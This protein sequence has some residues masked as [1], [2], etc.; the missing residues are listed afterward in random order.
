[1]QIG[2]GY[3]ST[4]KEIDVGTARLAAADNGG[5]VILIQLLNQNLVINVVAIDINS[6]PMAMVIIFDRNNSKT[7]LPFEMLIPMIESS[8]LLDDA[9]KTLFL[10]IPLSVL[11]NVENAVSASIA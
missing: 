10:A 5:K 2:S 8:W 9:G 4:K 11:G 1:M 6:A 3:L 7:T